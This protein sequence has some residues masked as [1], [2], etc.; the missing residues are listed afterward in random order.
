L[1]EPSGAK[2]LPRRRT[3]LTHEFVQDSSL[4]RAMTAAHDADAGA[5]DLPL[6]LKKAPA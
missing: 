6:A 4:P 3:T 5:A 2:L 1:R